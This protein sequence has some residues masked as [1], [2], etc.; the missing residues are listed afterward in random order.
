MLARITASLRAMPDTRGSATESS[1][2]Q[3]EL[4]A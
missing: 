1:A 4:K 3:A 2:T